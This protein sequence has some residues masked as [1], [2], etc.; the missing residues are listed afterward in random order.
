MAG[1]LGPRWFGVVVVR[2]WTQN[3]GR[4]KDVTL[5][6]ARGGVLD[7]VALTEMKRSRWVQYP[8]GYFGS[9]LHWTC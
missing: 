8:K 5:V 4:W 3:D 7:Q 2:K 9:G 6:P 1:N